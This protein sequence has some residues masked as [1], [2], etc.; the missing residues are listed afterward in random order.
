ME[1]QAET[2]ADTLNRELLDMA[3]AAARDYARSLGRKVSKRELAAFIVGFTRGV[4]A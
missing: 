1:P 4:T 3:T 2:L